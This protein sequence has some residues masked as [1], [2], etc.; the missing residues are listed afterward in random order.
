MRKFSLVLLVLSVLSFVGWTSTSQATCVTCSGGHC[1]FVASGHGS[2][3]EYPWDPEFP[4]KLSCPNCPTDPCNPGGGGG[5]GGC[6]MFEPGA[7]RAPVAPNQAVV[8]TGLLYQSEAHVN[9]KV[10]GGRG[11]SVR[12]LPGGVFPEMTADGVAR[13][14]EGLAPEAAGQLALG[15][16]FTNVNNAGIPVSFMTLDGEGFGFL[17]ATSGFG[18]NVQV[19]VRG[20]TKLVRALGNISLTNSDLLLVDV[21]MRGK[22]YIL[23]LKSEVIDGSSSDA[24]TRVR[25]ITDSMRDS[26]RLYPNPFQIPIDECP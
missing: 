15:H 4:C 19:K 18:A 16:G 13:A 1:T 23:A 3:V 8:T 22:A 25:V 7:A 12:V 2:C 24:N 9:A 14:I 21:S 20:M 5:G 6:V 10:F 26:Y 17:P 11:R